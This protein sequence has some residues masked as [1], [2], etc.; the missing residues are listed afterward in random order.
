MPGVVAATAQDGALHVEAH[1]PTAV[2][3]AVVRALVE[4][5][6]A[7]VE[8]QVEQLSLESI[9]FEIMGVR[10]GAGGEAT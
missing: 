3:P 5:G 4:A 9:Y 6:A 2:A 7:I 8:V 1:D 10:P